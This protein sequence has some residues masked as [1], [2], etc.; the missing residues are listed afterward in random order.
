MDKKLIKKTEKWVKE[1]YSN[2]DHLIRTGYWVKKLYPDA[3]DT[4]IIAAITHD[5]ERAFKE[6]RTTPSPEMKGAKWDDPVYN[7]W[8]SERSSR[9]IQKYLEKEKT[10]PNLIKKITRLVNCH[11]SGGWKEADF[12]RD[13]D[14]ISFLEVNTP[15]FIS[16]IPKDLSKE[17]VKEKFDYMYQRISGAEAKKIAEPLY[18][19]ALDILNSAHDLQA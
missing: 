1:I 13:A 18:K 4:L 10:E 8:H 7:K 11:E 15:Y 14:S 6:G 2:A 16:L 17:D 3:D 5:I 19:K 12:L 9:F